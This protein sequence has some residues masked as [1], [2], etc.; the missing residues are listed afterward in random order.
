MHYNFTSTLSGVSIIKWDN[1]SQQQLVSATWSPRDTG[2]HTVELTWEA[3]VLTGKVDGTQRVQ[4]TDH[5]YDDHVG[6]GLRGSGTS[7]VVDDFYYDDI[8]S[9]PTLAISPDPM[10]ELG[11]DPAITLTGTDTAWDPN[12]NTPTFT[13]NKGSITDQV[14]DSATTAHAN[15]HL[16]VVNDT[17]TF[18]DPSTGATDEVALTSTLNVE[19]NGTIDDVL[20]ILGTPAVGHTVT[21]DQVTELA[22]LHMP[23]TPPSVSDIIDWFVAGFVGATVPEALLD[24]LDALYGKLP[25]EQQILS[26]ETL[27]QTEL[28]WLNR[29]LGLLTDDV[30]AIAG[31][32]ELSLRATINAICGVPNITVSEVKALID[33]LTSSGYWDLAGIKTQIDLARGANNRDLTQVYDLVYSLGMPNLQAI[34]DELD[35]IT[36]TRDTS[37]PALHTITD[38]IQT[39]VNGLHDDQATAFSALT[40]A[41]VNTLQTILDALAALDTVLDT[42]VT[43]IRGDISDLQT[44]LTPELT[45]IKS[46]I[47]SANAALGTIDAVVD[48]IKTKVDSLQNTD[49]TAVNASLARIE[50]AIAALATPPP[51]WPGQAN[52]TLGTAVPLSA[53]LRIVGP[54][55][56]VI[57]Q[58][59]T[60][61]QKLSNFPMGDATYSYRLG[62]VA[63]EADAGWLEPWQYLGFDSALYCPR[64]MRQAAAVRI[65]YLGNAEGTAQP[66]ATV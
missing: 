43:N 1:L 51:I 20:A 62:F 31:E 12:T 63:F 49:L 65:R 23:D 58:L 34:L 39:S 55:D 42:G 48:A 52:V 37:L 57:I 4:V 36:G 38:A 14:I 21:G 15:Y 61:P 8:A 18:T 16:P 7:S 59:A 9:N 32:E 19:A 17:A 2:P 33:A 50:A 6:F 41:G 47:A 40:G 29:N 46:G 30:A 60:V 22:E 24:K 56:G 13:V 53:D 27:A 54:L 5:T 26:M 66:W 3:G 44:W 25:A 64:Q 45:T 10:E 11:P 35:W 28:A